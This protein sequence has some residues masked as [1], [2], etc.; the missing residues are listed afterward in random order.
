MRDWLSGGFVGFASG[1]GL[2]A[3]V[4]VFLAG[5]AWKKQEP[6][7]LEIGG[8]PTAASV[9]VPAADMA[10]ALLAEG[11]TPPAIK[12]EEKSVEP[13][14]EKKATPAGGSAKAPVRRKGAVIE[15]SPGAAVSAFATGRIVSPASD[16]FKLSPQRASVP[17]PFLLP[18]KPWFAVAALTTEESESRDGT[19]AVCTANRSLNT[20]LTWAKSPAEA[21]KQARSEGKLVFLIHVSGNFE[22]PGFT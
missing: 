16:P 10:L 1:A 14:P 8:H 22:D 9:P 20:A 7:R 17:E 18:E 2:C 5:H 11:S 4:G 3:A 6:H 19:G 12:P 15:R 13:A 21:A